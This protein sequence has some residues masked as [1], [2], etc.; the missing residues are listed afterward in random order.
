MATLSRQFRLRICYLH[1]LMYP[2]TNCRRRA[3]KY[4]HLINICDRIYENR[5]F[6]QKHKNRV[7]YI[8]GFLYLWRVQQMWKRGDRAFRRKDITPNASAIG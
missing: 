4:R 3:T 5:P 2:T 7:I 6:R 1:V 8:R